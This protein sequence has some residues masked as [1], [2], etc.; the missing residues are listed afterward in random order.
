MTSAPETG[1]RLGCR[2]ASTRPRLSASPPLIGLRPFLAS[3]WPTS[4]SGRVAQ[5]TGPCPNH[6]G[7]GCPSELPGAPIL[8]GFFNIP[9]QRATRQSGF[10]LIC[11]LVPR[12]PR[13]ALIEV[14]VRRSKLA[15]SLRAIWNSHARTT[16]DGGAESQVLLLSPQYSC[17]FCSAA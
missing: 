1:I 4:S 13:G 2:R 3:T 17:G 5:V 14:C 9:K 16:T 10:V 11:R 6:G 15:R 7:W 8:C 12:D